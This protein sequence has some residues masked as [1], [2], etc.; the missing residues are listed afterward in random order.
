[1]TVEQ[2]KEI[3]GLTGENFYFQVKKNRETM[4]APLEALDLSTRAFNSLKRSNI[5]TIGELIN[6]MENLRTQTNLSKAGRNIGSRSSFEIML[7]LWL[8]EKKQHGDEDQQDDFVHDTLMERES[9][10]EQMKDVDPELVAG[11]I[12]RRK[13]ATVE[14]ARK[15]TSKRETEKREEK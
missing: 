1:M 2:L 15:A 13:T 4:N 14:K 6:M 10:M 5:N 9:L 12:A 7:A 8:W 11:E 3:Y